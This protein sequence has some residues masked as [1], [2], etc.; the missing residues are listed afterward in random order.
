MTIPAARAFRRL[1]QKLGDH[2]VACRSR[3]PLCRARL[4]CDDDAACVDISFRLFD[5]LGKIV[6]L[7]DETC[8]SRREGGRLIIA[9]DD[10]RGRQEYISKTPGERVG[11]IYVDTGAMYRALALRSC[12]KGVICG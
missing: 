4:T 1:G 2:R 12:V 11:F 10:R 5:L 6:C 9:I 7:G 8:D 3:S